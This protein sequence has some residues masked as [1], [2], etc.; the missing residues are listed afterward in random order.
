VTARLVAARA[1]NDKSGL[2]QPL[3]IFGKRR[4][5]HQTLLIPIL[6]VI[7]A[8]LVAVIGWFVAHQFNVYRDRRNKRQDMIVQYLVEAYRRLESAANREKTEEQAFAFE[9]AI[10]DIQ[11]LGSTEQISATIRFLHAH[12]S[13]SGAVVGE[14]LCLLRNDLRRELGLSP[15]KNNPVIFRFER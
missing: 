2:N 14:V 1:L 11:L 4:M 13:S 3:T 12:A 15:A 5:D 6:T 8:P 7:L 10:A 9:S